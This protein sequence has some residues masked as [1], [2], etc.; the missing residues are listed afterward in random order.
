MIESKI[1][2]LFPALFPV[3]KNEDF[4]SLLLFVVWTTIKENPG[5]T[6]NKLKWTLTQNYA[7]SE[8]DINLALSSLVNSQ[9]FDSVSR[10]EHTHRQSGRTVVHLRPKKS[11]LLEMQKIEKLL[12]KT[13]PNLTYLKAS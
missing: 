4:R 5:I 13:N 9:M 12:I 10:F 1:Y 2:E 3:Y 6:E 7:F 11:R 8:E